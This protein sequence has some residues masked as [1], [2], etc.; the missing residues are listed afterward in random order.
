MFIYG[1]D[2]SGNLEIIREQ[3]YTRFPVVEGSKDNVIGIVNTK[4]FFLAYEGN[5]DLDFAALLQPV[6]AVS[7]VTPVNELLKKCSR[8]ACIWRF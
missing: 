2:A 1:Q 6:M 8:K 4:Q 5:P 7:E 3:Q